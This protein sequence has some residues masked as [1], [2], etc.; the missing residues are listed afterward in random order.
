MPHLRVGNVNIV[1]HHFSDH[2]II[3]IEFVEKTTNENKYIGSEPELFAP[4]T[5]AI[6][7]AMF[8]I[9]QVNYTN[10]FFMKRQQ[11]LVTGL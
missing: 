8:H 11:A 3:G 1:I 5:I 7:S 6:L 4:Y 10:I 9:I 2:S